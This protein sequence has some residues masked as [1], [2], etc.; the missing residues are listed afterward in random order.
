[1]RIVITWIANSFAILLVARLVHSVSVDSVR[2]AFVAGAVLTAVNAIVRPL[3]VIL[4]LPLTVLTL[5]LFYFVVT[6]ICLRLAAHLVPGFAVRGWFMTI[7]AS[8][9]IGLSSAIIAKV[10]RKAT[11]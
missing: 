3:L 6:G 2:D 5:G 11:D 7:V 10:L 8:I 4:T 1:M 9:L